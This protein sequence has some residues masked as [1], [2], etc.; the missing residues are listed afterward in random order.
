MMLES[1]VTRLKCPRIPSPAISSSTLQI[2]KNMIAYAH[3]NNKKAH[4]I[5]RRQEQANHIPDQNN[6]HRSKSSAIPNHYMPNISDSPSQWMWICC[7]RHRFPCCLSPS[8][9]R[10]HHLLPARPHQPPS[11]CE[12]IHD[13]EVGC[14]WIQRAPT[15]RRSDPTVP[16]L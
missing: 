14:S 9:R 11:A 3:I 6:S 1:T 7:R 12:V 15:S 8:S 13:S 5:S 2:N 4:H 16:D 10:C